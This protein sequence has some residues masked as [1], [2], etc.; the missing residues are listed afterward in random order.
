MQQ[1][2]LFSGAVDLQALEDEAI[3]LL[4]EADPEPQSSDPEVLEGQLS[5][6]GE[7]WRRSHAVQQALDA[8]DLVAACSALNGLLIIYPED[9]RLNSHAIRVARLAQRL[10]HDS[11]QFG[12][13]QALQDLGSHVPAPL[14][15]AYHRK[16][17]TTLEQAERQAQGAASRDAGFHYLRA[18]D[19]P[20]A[21]RA[22]RT[23]L[24]QNPTDARARAYLADVL[25]QLD[26]TQAARAEYRTALLQDP[27]A[28]DW[29]NVLD[30]DVADLPAIAEQDYGLEEAPESWAAAL[31]VV[32][33]VF[34]PPKTPSQAVQADPQR[35]AGLQF[36]EGIAQELGA[37]TPEARVE[38]RRALKLL[39][40]PLFRRYLARYGH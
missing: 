16:L 4:A 12:Y 18:G 8:F 31:G 32:D 39:C 38:A 23:A 40:P 11:R 19:L 7:P 13:L 30:P 34:M 24:E 26:K 10:V 37:A 27:L 22:L 33:G 15:E 14:Q 3:S 5:L 21:E 17:A 20:A 29:P 35:P 6:F 25:V 28:V 9:P 1:L 36:Y 2:D